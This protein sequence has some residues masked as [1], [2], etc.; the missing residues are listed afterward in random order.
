MK[1]VKELGVLDTL[2]DSGKRLLVEWHAPGVRERH[3]ASL[4]I[5][6]LRPRERRGLRLGG[7]LPSDAQHNATPSTVYRPHRLPSRSSSS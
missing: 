5:V 6:S 3:L 4:Y 1:H 7:L 2:T